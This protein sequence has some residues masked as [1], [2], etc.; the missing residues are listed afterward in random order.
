MSEV[1]ETLERIK[2][3]KGVIGV[4][5]ATA[6]GVPIRPSKGMVRETTHLAFQTPTSCT[7]TARFESVNS[8]YFQWFLPCP[9]SGPCEQEDEITSTY[10]AELA[11]LAAKARNVV[12]DLDPTVCHL[13]P[14]S[15]STHMLSSLFRLCRFPF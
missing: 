8:A 4:V 7:C 14:P 6:D 9:H 13:A 1:E 11:Q 3:H 15:I 10:A 2:G 5:I 12:R